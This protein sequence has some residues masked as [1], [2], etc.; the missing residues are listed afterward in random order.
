MHHDSR[1]MSFGDHLEELRL[2]VVLSLLVPVPLFIVAVVFGRRLLEFIIAPLISALQR[3]GQPAM[4]LATSPVEPFATYM[5]V[6]AVTALLGSLPWILYQLWLFI[7]PG[8]YAR[9]K[10]FVYFLIP[11]SA[12]LTAAALAFLYKI[13]LPIA[14]FF[15]INFG[16]GLVTQDVTK[17]ELSPTTRLAQAVVLEGDPIEPQAVGAAWVNRPLNELRIQLTETEIGGIPLSRGG[18]GG[19]A[20]QY[21]LSEYINLVFALALAFAITSQLPVVL[22]LLSWVGLVHHSVLVKYRRHALVAAVVA[23][24]LL[25]TQD[26]ASLVLL[27][28]TMYALFE[29]GILLMRLVPAERI[30]RGIGD[31]PRTDGDQGD[32]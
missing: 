15:L 20:Q 28:G 9:E 5:K 16:A 32:E 24:A 13:L 6:A 12:L 29:F 25:P 18:A 11:L 4:L 1:I 10:R 14:L 26:P 8:L 31:R 22:M 19:V 27:G 23:G 17:V 30:A 21:R 3:A 7:A 2:R